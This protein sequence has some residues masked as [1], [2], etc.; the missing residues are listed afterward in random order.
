M[1]RIL[2][3]ILALALI[4]ALTPAF[5]SVELKGFDKDAGYTYVAFGQYPQD[6]DG[7]VQPIIW[8]VLSVNGNEAYLL[9]DAILEVS[10]IHNVAQ[11]YPGWEKADLNAWLQKEFV[12]KAFM[13]SAHTALLEKD[14]GRVSLPS[15]DDLKNKDFG[16]TDNM[17]R[18]ALGTMYADEEGL[19]YYRHKGHSPYW[20]RTPSVKK[21]AH[22]SIKLE[23]NLG[24][25]GVTAVDMGVRPVITLNLDLLQSPGG[26]GSIEDP[27]VLE[28]LAKSE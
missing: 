7:G 28:A 20:T 17:S 6:K 11:G 10:R 9:S 18:R 26:T 2:T 22:R 12:E 13:P 25:L 21:F 1:R 8:R 19:F 24:Y 4:L 23:G 27:I 15:Y 3:F 14:Y 5:A 16:F